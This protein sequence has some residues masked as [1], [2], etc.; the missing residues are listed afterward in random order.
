MINIIT[1]RLPD[2][3]ADGPTKVVLNLMKGL[4]RVGYPYVINKDVV[5]TRR[6]WVANE[7]LPLRYLPRERPFTV[8]G[9]SIWVLP[10]DIRESINWDRIVYV[11]PSHWTRRLWEFY[12]FNK[13]PMVVWPVGI[14]LDEYRPARRDRRSRSVV[15]YHKDRDP[16]ELPG[17]ITALANRGL[18][19]ILIMYGRY[20]QEDF[21]EAVRSSA[22]VVWHGARESQ[23]LAL[24]EALA[25]DVPVLVWD[26][27]RL[28][29][30]YGGYKF[31]HETDV[32]GVTAAPY[33]DSRC[34]IRIVQPNSIEAAMDEMLDRISEFEPRAFVSEN[35]S[36]EGQA[37]AFV[38]IWEGWGLTWE[39][40][41]REQPQCDAPFRLPL[42]H[43]SAVL[44][45]KTKRFLSSAWWE[46]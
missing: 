29:D 43:R 1:R 32:I 40:G 7:S 20:R 38:A 46:P 44:R 41:V 16:Q 9:P 13:C 31:S 17:V 12:G 4:D 8:A 11:Q 33:F 37:R 18:D 19:T 25:C 2:V 26:I 35:L 14:D 15:V 36:L 23:G 45:A 39:E 22:F 30:A 42:R 3:C 5:S 10:G 28:T 27:P 24:E 21:L 34:G 6:L